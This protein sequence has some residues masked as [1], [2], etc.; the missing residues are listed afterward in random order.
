MYK[1]FRTCKI[2]LERYEMI[3]QHFYMRF[4]NCVNLISVPS[5]SVWL[6]HI[7]L[8]LAILVLVLFGSF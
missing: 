1:D 4:E 7:K 5:K 2:F 8:R 3:Y 6:A